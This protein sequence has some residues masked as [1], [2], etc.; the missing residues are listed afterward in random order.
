MKKNAQTIEKTN[1]LE[2]SVE[3][4]ALMAAAM[5]A[6]EL[7]KRCESV[8]EYF[9][10]SRVFQERKWYLFY[11]FF[12]GNQWVDINR[13]TGELF[14][15]P[16][17]SWRV[18]LVI[19]KT[20]VVIRNIASQITDKRPT[21]DVL[22]ASDDPDDIENSKLIAYAIEYL[23]DRLGVQDKI[24]ELVFYMLIFGVAYMK[25]YWTG[26]E[27]AVDVL[28][29][30]SVFFDPFSKDPETSPGVIHATWRTIEYI[31]DTYGVD[32]PAETI[33]STSA[34]QQRIANEVIGM[35]SFA[36]PTFS[37]GSGEK[38]KKEE[39]QEQG[40]IVKEG[41]FRKRGG[42]EWEIITWANGKLLKR[43]DFPY[44]HGKNPITK[45][46]ANRVPGEWVGISEV[47][48]LLPLQ[49][50]LNKGRSQVIEHK[51]LMSRGKWLV[52]K[53]AGVSKNAFT[54]E[55]GEVIE[56]NPGAKPEQ[57]DL[58]PLPEYVFEL[59]QWVERSME[60]IAGIH[61][62]SMGRVPT[63]A[64]S[65]RAIEALRESDETGI[66]P[67]ERNLENGLER[68][69]YQLVGLMQQYYTSEKL[70][71]TTGKYP[72]FFR[73]SNQHIKEG[74]DVRVNLG[75]AFAYTRLGKREELKELYELGAIDRQTLLE[76]YEFGNVDEILERAA[77]PNVSKR[78]KAE[79]EELA[80]QEDI[81]EM[82]DGQEPTVSPTDDHEVRVR[83]VEE[84]IAVHRKEFDQYPDEILEVFENYLAAHTAYMAKMQMSP[85]GVPGKGGQ[86]MPAD[87]LPPEQTPA[88]M[89]EEDMLAMTPAT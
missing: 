50:E 77:E 60:D 54:S 31:K 42:K 4:E 32:V 30:F 80:A 64:K 40:A 10:R 49:K 2:M 1:A 29:P 71:R 61:D 47:E 28:D 84:Y 58:K 3:Q 33:R 87:A 82:L 69:G 73:F 44:K 51:N 70:M 35:A 62:V 75:T 55:P 45:F 59:L 43:R 78:L 13:V 38:G 88:G 86:Q 9:K 25:T 72:R 18:R 48:N 12:R 83:A 8:Y 7:V 19:N 21:W 24:E 15:P 76:H 89:S 20:W 16:A 6:E 11:Q 52:P 39:Y 14:V 17:P 68:V 56:Y 74:V 57:A 23:Y 79:R 27:V 34:I 46:V 66:R 5:E 65:G 81:N 41:Y 85:T 37:A 22:P 67:K 36:S 63:G 53:N 26:E